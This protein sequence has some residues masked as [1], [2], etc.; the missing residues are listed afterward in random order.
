MQPFATPTGFTKI[1]KL[2]NLWHIL[3]CDP[4]LL[5]LTIA[6]FLRHL[7]NFAISTDL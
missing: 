5:A 6:E 1:T 4:I 7:L 2:Y 3:S